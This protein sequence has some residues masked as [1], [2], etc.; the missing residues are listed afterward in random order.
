MHISGGILQY[1]IDTPSNILQYIIEAQ[2]AAVYA[3]GNTNQVISLH[4]N[5]IRARMGINK[6]FWVGYRV[7]NK[8]QL[9][10]RP[11]RM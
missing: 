6:H 9:R 4:S 10:I 7:S 3:P 8:F 5:P 2:C 1:N 11:R